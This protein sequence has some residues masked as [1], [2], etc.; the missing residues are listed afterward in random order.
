MGWID[1]VSPCLSI[2]L[3]IIMSFED[4]FWLVDSD[5]S[6]FHSSEW[7]GEGVTSTWYVVYRICMALFMS[8]GITLHF[9]STLDTLGVKW[10]IYMTNQGRGGCPGPTVLTAEHLGLQALDF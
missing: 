2:L 6:L 8:T 4:K 5:V 10:F 1:K 9:V 7:D 3:C